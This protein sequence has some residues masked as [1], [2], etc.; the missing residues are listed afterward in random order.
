MI[1]VARGGGQCRI[2]INRPDK[3][4]ALTQD[5]LDA[6]L[7]AVEQTTEPVLVL[8]GAGKV[9]SAG[10]D[11]AEVRGGTL[12]TSP[13]WEALSAAVAAFPG[14]SVAALNGDCAGGA[15]GMVLACDLRVAAPTTR[16]FYPVMRLG[17]L[18]QPS[19]PGR[20]TRLVGPS[21]ARMILMAGQRI[22]ADEALTWGL[23]DRLDAD[24][25]A[26][27]DTLTEQAR[28]ANPAHVAAIKALCTGQ[29]P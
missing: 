13:T 6:L 11:L 15:I 25:D 10:A 18:P 14:L 17:V 20:L 19:D 1:K 7:Q 26:A 28:A 16:L 21:R 23:L 29:T 2:T 27:V 9:F 22:C 3:A 5:M 24:L 4:N 12:A 8:T